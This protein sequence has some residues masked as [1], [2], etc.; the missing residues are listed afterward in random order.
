MWILWRGVVS[1]PR[2]GVFFH[3]RDGEGESAGSYLH[4]WEEEWQTNLISKQGKWSW[5]SYFL[6]ITVVFCSSGAFNIGVRI[7]RMHVSRKWNFLGFALTRLRHTQAKGMHVNTHLIFKKTK[8]ASLIAL[9]YYIIVKAFK[10]KGGW[11][12]ALP[13]YVYLCNSIKEWIFKNP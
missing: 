7:M 12:I 10:G 2:Y 6:S 4:L 13:S 3:P 9:T 1:S 5:I 8:N 11:V